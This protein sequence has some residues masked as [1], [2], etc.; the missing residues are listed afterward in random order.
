MGMDCIAGVNRVKQ[1]SMPGMKRSTWKGIHGA[2]ILRGMV[3]LGGKAV[4]RKWWVGNQENQR[5]LL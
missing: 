2:P 4:L 5:D 3:A 1:S